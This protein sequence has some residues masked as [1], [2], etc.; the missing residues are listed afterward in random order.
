MGSPEWVVGVD[1]DL[2]NR[3]ISS[4]C[5]VWG[6]RSTGMAITGENGTPLIRSEGRRQRLE[7]EEGR[8]GDE[9]EG[10]GEG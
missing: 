8:K 9:R 5:F 6:K 2:W 1:F 3:M 7:R 4:Q 10:G